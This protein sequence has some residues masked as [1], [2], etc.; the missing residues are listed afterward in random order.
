VVKRSLSI[1]LAA[2]DANRQLV[3]GVRLLLSV[4]PLISIGTLLL[5]RPFLATRVS[6][7][8]PDFLLCLLTAGA[9]ITRLPFT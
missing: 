2:E 4:P 8:R 7:L 5:A 6:R 1:H 3:T 9:C